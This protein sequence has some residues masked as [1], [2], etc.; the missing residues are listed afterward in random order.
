[1]SR[2]AVTD[3]PLLNCLLDDRID[4]SNGRV[5][6][7]QRYPSTDRHDEIDRTGSELSCKGMV[8]E[9]Q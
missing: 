8:V 9:K 5:G 6:K 2:E 1:M 3:K 7:L 4:A